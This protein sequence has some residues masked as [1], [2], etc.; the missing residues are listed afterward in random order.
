MLEISK[1][2][3]QLIRHYEVIEN[4]PDHFVSCYVAL[5]TLVPDCSSHS[6]DLTW[7]GL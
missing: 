4:F 3:P 1:L 5:L 7:S 2:V 6:Q